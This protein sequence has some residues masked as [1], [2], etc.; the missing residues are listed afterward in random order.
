MSEPLL[1]PAFLFRFSVACR[2]S[3]KARSVSELQLADEHAIPTFGEMEGRPLFADVR[4]AWCEKGL[5]FTC[6]VTGKSQSPWCRASRAEDSDGLQVW[7]DT[8]NAHNI[9]RA[10]RF[11]H[12]F[13]F[14]PTGSGRQMNEP[15]AETLPIQRAREEPKRAAKGSLEIAGRT[16]AGGYE[17]Q[18]F[19][20]AD[21]LTGFDPADHPRLGFSYAVIDRELGWQTFS[22]G[23]EFPFT[24]DPSLW[25]TLELVDRQR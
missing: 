14:L 9:H 18:A 3:Q 4:A 22:V 23:P 10:T 20:A 12:R 17:V 24:A 2:Y 8:R 7:I 16:Y 5:A 13:I 21:S 19:V 6:R 15:T 25:G 11:C 1:S